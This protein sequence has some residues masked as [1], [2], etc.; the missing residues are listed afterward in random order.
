[1]SEHLRHFHQIP[2]MEK[3]L[4]IPSSRH[5]ND[6]EER[7]LCNASNCNNMRKMFSML[8][9]DEEHFFFKNTQ[10]NCGVF[11]PST[12]QSYYDCGP[13][14]TDALYHR[15]GKP[16][17]FGLRYDEMGWVKERNCRKTTHNMKTDRQ[18]DR[19]KSK[20]K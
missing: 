17:S 13:N 4:H 18:T 11:M 7:N 3:L 16:P 8:H 1:M 20:E 14:I 6:H 12:C 19:Q 5:K 15:Q 10:V 9:D 2:Q